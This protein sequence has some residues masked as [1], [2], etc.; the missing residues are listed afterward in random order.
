MWLTIWRS[1]IENYI[2]KNIRQEYLKGDDQPKSSRNYLH[3]PSDCYSP[4]RIIIH[5]KIRKL[6]NDSIG[7][8]IT[9]IAEQT[10]M[11]THNSALHKIKERTCTGQYNQRDTYK[12]LYQI[13]CTRHQ[14]THQLPRLNNRQ[15]RLTSYTSQTAKK[16]QKKNSCTIKKKEKENQAI[17]HWTSSK[18]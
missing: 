15:A 5:S 13:P 10:L 11:K 4:K 14:H 16:N 2:E 7:K 17:Y 6:E 8:T 3:L 18:Q 1:Y 9:N 12:E